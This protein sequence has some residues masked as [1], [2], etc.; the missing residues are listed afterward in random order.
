MTD[1]TWMPRIEPDL[2]H[3]CGACID[4]CEARALGWAR[5]DRAALIHPERCV[6]CGSCET[7]CPTGAIEL[8]F[9][10]CFTGKKDES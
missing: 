3:G 2:C 10:I 4:G 6:Y 5:N 9:L 8:P 1:Q 7:R